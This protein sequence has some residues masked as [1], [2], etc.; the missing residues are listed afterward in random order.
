MREAHK[1]KDLYALRLKTMDTPQ[2]SLLIV[3]ERTTNVEL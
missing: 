1:S 2:F 3:A